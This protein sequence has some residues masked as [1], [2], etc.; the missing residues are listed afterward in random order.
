MGR[1]CLRKLCCCLCLDKAAPYQYEIVY[2][3][4]DDGGGGGGGGGGSG[5]ATGSH[6]TGDNDSSRPDYCSTDGDEDIRL[7]SVT[8]C[9]PGK[10]LF[11]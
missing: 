7:S 1:S 2:K 11:N 4:Q 8:D 3:H 10:I 6:L 5:S 9:S